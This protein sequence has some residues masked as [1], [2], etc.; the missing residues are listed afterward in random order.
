MSFHF[1]VYSSPL[2]FGFVQAWIYA[3]LLWIRSLRE[4]R[5]SEALLGAILVALAF[6]IW[7]Y[8]LGF[9]GIAILW[10]ELDFFP[11]DLGFLLPPLVYFYL[12]AQSD[13]TFRFGWN[14]LWHAL[15]FSLYFFYHLLVFAQG[16]AFVRY[17]QTA[18]HYAGVDDLEFVVSTIQKIGYLYASFRLYRRYLTWIGT[19]FSD[20]EPVRLRWFRNLLLALTCALTIDLSF[21]LVG[22]WV[23]L[24]YWD[25]WWS[26]LTGVVL[27]YYVSIGGYAQTRVA[28]TLRFDPHKEDSAT[29]ERRLTTEAR[30]TELTVL[31]D[32]MATERPYLE[33]NLSVTEL[34]RRL[35]V[36]PPALSHLINSGTGGNFNY[37][38]NRY[39]VEEFKRRVADGENRHLSLIALAYDCGFNSKATFN[40]VFK[41]QT[42]Q[43]PKAY[44]TNPLAARRTDNYTPRTV[45][46]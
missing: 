10:R 9:G 41:Q 11:R 26:S 1:S 39:R 8:M 22:R 18:V 7:L 34:A 33:P 5:L 21:A 31:L 4:G 15:P 43:T 28:S 29:A 40:R 27:I 37:F 19:Q 23:T 30:S 38:V 3:L 42:G 32:Y 12:R 44:T 25:N 2:L 14:H 36:S 46:K 16:P 45:N 20:L 17:W 35:H 6:E 24:S 13:G